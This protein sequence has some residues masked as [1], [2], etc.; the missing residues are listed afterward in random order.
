MF[1]DNKRTLRDTAMRRR[2]QQPDKDRLSRT[3]VSALVDLPEFRQAERPVLYVDVRDEVL[4]WPLITTRLA[5]GSPVILPFCQDG[6][7][8]LCRIDQWT[9]LAP[10]A[11]G[12]LE[13][14]ASIR[15]AGDRHT[16]A[17][18]IDLIVVP[19]VAFDRRGHRLGH[20]F[21][22]YDRLLARVSDSTSL[23]GLAYDCQLFDNVPHEPHDV[24]VDV[25]VT[26]SA[27]YRR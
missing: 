20:G 10:G 23:V 9:Q 8:Q 11:Y 1:P 6:D 16:A 15:L 2:H 24:A 17:A 12:I 5:S 22:Y 18:D 14:I 27:V 7:L 21:G 3:I 4:T 26:E 19:G 13:P 25:I